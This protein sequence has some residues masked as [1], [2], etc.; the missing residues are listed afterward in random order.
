MIID[1]GILTDRTGKVHTIFS[2]SL[3]L[4]HRLGYN[5]KVNQ[6]IRQTIHPEL[7]KAFKKLDSPQKIQAFLDSLPINLEKGGQTLR[8]PLRVLQSKKAHCLEAALLA[9]AAFWW[10]RQRPL[11]LDLKTTKDDLEHVVALFK[12]RGHWGA[13]SKTNHAVLRYR[14]PVYKTVRELAM[15]YFHEYFL[16][17]GRKTMRSFS[18]PFDLRRYGTAWLTA[19]DFL[20]QIERD[21]DGSPHF[22][23]ANKNQIAKL[24]RADPIEIAASKLT[25]W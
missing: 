9:A 4:V 18:W 19:K 23:A 22:A 24:R 6:K 2:V 3:R 7:A 20:W 14:E 1:P 21:L 11:L 8:S 10:H 5:C 13:I 25:E 12:N 16:E 17:D 15:S